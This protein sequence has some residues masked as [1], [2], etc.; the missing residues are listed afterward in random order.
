M[1]AP[2]V[3]EDPDDEMRAKRIRKHQLTTGHVGKLGESR[4]QIVGTPGTALAL[5]NRCFVH[6]TVVTSLAGAS[7]MLEVGPS[8]DPYSVRVLSLPSSHPQ[9]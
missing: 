1:Q 6:P 8:P 9:A 4:M 5:T 3:D 7:L 2:P